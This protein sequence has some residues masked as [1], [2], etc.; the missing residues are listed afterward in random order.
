MTWHDIVYDEDRGG[1]RDSNNLL[2]FPSDGDFFK[3]TQGALPWRTY[4][5]QWNILTD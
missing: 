5:E 4:D 1:P 3:R 2:S